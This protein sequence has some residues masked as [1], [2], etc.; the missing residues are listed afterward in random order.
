[1]NNTPLLH[2]PDWPFYNLREMLQSEAFEYF[3]ADRLGNDL[4]ISDPERANRIHEAAEHG[5]DGS[6][7]YEH[8]Q[9]WRDFLSLY[10]EFDP[11]FDERGRDYRL[12]PGIIDSITDE[13][14]ACE[15][16]HDKNGSLHEEIG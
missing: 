3:R 15:D 16:W 14:N 6:T 7:H 4:F 1:M 12:C 9:D 10:R 13:I 8:I 5:C 2:A 11:D